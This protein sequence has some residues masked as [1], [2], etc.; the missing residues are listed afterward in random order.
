MQKIK[1]ANPVVE[2]DGDEMTR[3]IWKFIK[4]KLITPYLD[5]DIKY[6]DSENS[7]I[8]YDQRLIQFQA[9]DQWIRKYPH[10]I[11]L[12]A[13]EDLKTIRAYSETLNQIQKIVAEK[14]L[15][16]QFK[17]IAIGGGSITDFVGFIA[18]TYQRG[19]AWIAVPSTWLCAIDSAHGGKNGLNLNG[20]KNQI[21]T[22]H[23]PDEVI[24]CDEL[25]K[26]QPLERLIE[27]AGEILKITLISSAVGFNQFKLDEG[28]VLRNLNSYIK[29]KNKIVKIDPFETK[30]IRY[31]LNLGH[32][33]GLMELRFYLE[34]FLL[35]ILV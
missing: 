30:K 2:L 7:I 27:S 18:A 20:V 11:A 3:I 33:V 8:F 6:F 4:N 13:G 16:R 12:P 29:F 21:G 22:I 19:H 35:F 5:I 28:F 15:G 23:F 34:L 9:F 32:T 14:Q 17:L 24:I 26:L 10:S 31:L 25:L 1:V